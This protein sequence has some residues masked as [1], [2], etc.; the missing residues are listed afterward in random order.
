M[1]HGCKRSLSGSR[2]LLHDLYHFLLIRETE[3]SSKNQNCNPLIPSLHLLSKVLIQNVYDFPKEC[4][5]LET[6]FKRGSARNI[7]SPNSNICPRPP[8]ARGHVKCIQL[9]FKVSSLI[10][11]T[12][13]KALKSLPR[14]KT[15]LSL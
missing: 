7:L 4:Y 12:L 11:P 9:N 13:F 2:S 1:M 6:M 14:S 8:K 15:I 10:V 3:R 5:Q